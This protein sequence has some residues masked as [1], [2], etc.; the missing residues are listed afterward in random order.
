MT[1]VDPQVPPT[2]R[3]IEVRRESSTS[4]WVVAGIVAVVAVI[5]VTFM[6]VQQRPDA[7]T[8]DQVTQAQEQGRA[9]GVIE[10]AQSTVATSAQQA[11]LAAESAARQAG[12][13]ADAARRD[14]ERAAARPPTTRPTM[15]RPAV[16]AARR[17]PTANRRP[18]RNNHPLPRFGSADYIEACARPSMNPP[19][20]PSAPSMSR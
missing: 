11:Q 17:R 20:R 7:L 19:T 5:A 6:I 18:N 3:I 1:Y 8:Q 13:A 12:D 9:A 16:T 2:E 15:S 10:G 14:T 4:G